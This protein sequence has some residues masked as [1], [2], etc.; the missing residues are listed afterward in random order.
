MAFRFFCNVTNFIIRV[1]HT[2]TRSQMILVW[3][4][5]VLLLYTLCLKTP[6]CYT[7]K[8]SYYSAFHKVVQ[9]HFSGKVSKFTIFSWF[10]TPK[11]IK[12]GSIFAL[13]FK[14]GVFR[15]SVSAWSIVEMTGH[16][17][18]PHMSSSLC[19]SCFDGF[20]QP[21]AVIICNILG[22]LK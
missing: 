4:T 2:E 13:L 17:R 19:R 11:I 16:A 15:H 9:R 6:P 5:T 7:C 3:L 20:G 22:H 8:Q 10:C 21:M 14:A 1:R 18:L 12:I